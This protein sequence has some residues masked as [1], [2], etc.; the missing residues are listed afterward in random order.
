MGQVYSISASESLMFICRITYMAS[1]PAAYNLKGRHVVQRQMVLNFLRK[2]PTWT[3]L[4]PQD[5]IRAGTRNPRF[6][7]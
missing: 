5:R 1:L 7:K 4:Q 6:P 2:N 3:M